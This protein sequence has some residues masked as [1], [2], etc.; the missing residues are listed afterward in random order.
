LR[1]RRR[2]TWV[3]PESASRQEFPSPLHQRRVRADDGSADRAS[4]SPG[5]GM[6]P[7]LCAR[8]ASGLKARA[9]RL[10]SLASAAARCGRATQGPTADG[11]P[12]VRNDAAVHLRR[13]IRLVR[14]LQWGGGGGGWGGGVGSVVLGVSTCRQG[15]ARSDDSLSWHGSDLPCVSGPLRRQPLSPRGRRRRGEDLQSI[16][17]FYAHGTAHLRQAADLGAAPCASPGGRVPVPL[18]AADQPFV[19]ISRGSRSALGAS[20]RRGNPSGSTFQRRLRQRR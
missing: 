3:G 10:R 15:I 16:S 1:L 11:Q 2:R 17:C 13:L 8:R 19:A 7:A 9:R 6:E 18:T 5:T 14:G 20:P 4:I 12:A